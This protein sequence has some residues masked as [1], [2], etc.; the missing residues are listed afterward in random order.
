MNKLKNQIY[1]CDVFEEVEDYFKEDKPKF[2]KLFEE[3]IDLDVLI[4]QTFFNA[5][6]SSTGHP[7][8]YSLSSMLTALI[9][10]KYLVCLK[11]K[12]F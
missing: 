5:Y 3:Y 1:L 2:I 4:P 11:Q 7:R 8:D 10:Q 12:H 9:V 6:Y